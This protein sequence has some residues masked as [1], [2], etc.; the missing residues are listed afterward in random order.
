ML[1]CEVT[2]V[3]TAEVTVS[4]GIDGTPHEKLVT[5]S[6]YRIK[7]KARDFFSF[8]VEKTLSRIL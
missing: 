1:V 4:S 2:A 7:S 3:G 6:G 5:T 8:M